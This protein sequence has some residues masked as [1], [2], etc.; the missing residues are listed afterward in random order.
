MRQ[1]PFRC[2]VMI[3]EVLRGKYRA[4]DSPHPHFSGAILP[5]FRALASFCDGLRNLVHVINNMLVFSK[6][7]WHC[8]LG[9]PL[10]LNIGRD[11]SLRRHK[12]I[13]HLLCG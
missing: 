7:V 1:L 2:K 9:Q 11:L 3:S 6:R 13:S 5:L 10:A 12:A 8:H 4:S